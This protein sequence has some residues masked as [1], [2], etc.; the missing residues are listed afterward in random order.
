MYPICLS[1]EMLLCIMLNIQTIFFFLDTDIRYSMEEKSFKGECGQNT[2]GISEEFSHTLPMSGQE[3]D[4][5]LGISGT[6]G[7]S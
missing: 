5:E 7:A 6:L 1:S 4:R 2:N 3:L